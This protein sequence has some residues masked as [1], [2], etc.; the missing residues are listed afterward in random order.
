MGIRRPGVTE[1]LQAFAQQGLIRAER[2]LIIVLDRDGLLLKAGR[3]YGVPEAEF[4]R[5]IG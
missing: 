4:D 1:A 2:G 3:Y 5:L